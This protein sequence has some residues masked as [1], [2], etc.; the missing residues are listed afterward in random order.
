MPDLAEWRDEDEVYQPAEDTRL[1]AEAT[2]ETVAAGDRVLDVG[3]GSGF[4]AAVAA[5]AGADVVGVDINPHACAQA[6]RQGVPTVRGDLTLPFRDGVFDLV[7]FNPP[8]LPTAPGEAGD[9]WLERALSGGEDGRAVVEPFLD[10][11]CRVLAPG[12]VVLLLVSSLTG[13]D[14]VTDFAAERGLDATEVAA[15]KHP[16]ERLVVLRLTPR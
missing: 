14:E 15:E 11:V 3:T 7:L 8:Y 12:G 10:D 16:F 5:E 9:D 1:L 4:V 13:I 2:R 6:R